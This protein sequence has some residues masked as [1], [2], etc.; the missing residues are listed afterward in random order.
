M[1]YIDKNRA[2]RKISA[3][4][5]KTK[6]KL[7]MNPDSKVDAQD[8]PPESN[9]GSAQ[10]MKRL[11]YNQTKT[12]EIP[13]K[14]A[15]WM[16]L[17]LWLPLFAV[18]QGVGAS[19]WQLLEL[20]ELDQ[21]IANI[22]NMFIPVSNPALL[23]T[24]HANGLGWAHQ[25]D[26]EKLR[27]QYWL[28][29]NSDGLSYVYEY[30]KDDATGRSANQHLLAWGNELLP[31]HILPNLYG[32]LNYSW[33]NNK[34]SEGQFRSGFA[35]R[36]HASASLAFTWDNPYKASPYYR[37]GAA[38]R[39]LAFVP[40]VADHR[41][42]LSADMNYAKDGSDYKFQKPVLGLNTQ[43]LNGVNIGATYNLETETVFANFSLGFGNTELGT[44][45][46]ID[47]KNDND[48]FFIPYIHLPE[49]AFAPFLG[50]TG[51]NWYDM[52]LNQEIVSYRAP[53]YSLGPFKIF[54]K[55]QKS[56]EQV[57]EEIGKA[58]TDP[59]VQ[60][61]MLYNPSFSTSY[62]LMQE[63]IGALQ[64][65]KST[66]KKISVY[67]NNISNGGYVFASAVADKIY[68]NPMGGV[69]LRGISITSPYFRELLDT[70]GIDVLNFRSHKYK[71]AGNM[72]SE[73]EMTAAER[74]VYDSLLQ[75]IYGQMVAMIESGR[76][77]VFKKPVEELIDDGPYFLAVDALNAGLVDELIYEDEVMDR[78]KAEFKIGN[79]K[80]QMEDYRDYAW[81][82]PKENQIAVIYAS[83]SIV[84]GKGTP[85]TKIAHE[86][87]AKMI[88]AARKNKD[89]KGIILRVDSGGG[90]AQASD[91]ILRELELAR[92]ENKKPV[93]VS[94]AG[95]AASGGYYI[96]CK[97]DR[98][99]A[100]PATL[101]GSIGVIGLTF[102]TERLFNKIRVN[103]S[104]VKKGRNADF[105]SLYRS[106]SDEEIRRVEES[107]EA[108]YDDFVNKVDAGRPNLS[109]EQVHEYAQG[110]VWT[111]EQAYA[112][113]LIDDLGG[114]DKALEHM[115]DLT[116]IKGK[117]SLV[118]A[119]ITKDRSVTLGIPLGMGSVSP[120]LELY[121]AATAD[122]QKLYEL[123]R[124]FHNEQVL[125][126]SPLNFADLEF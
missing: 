88:R 96:A 82:K 93:V 99:I 3:L 89:Y 111:G 73:T 48:S 126:L 118:N 95:V 81:S 18:A 119:T 1:F 16:M 123:W 85:G 100:D 46:G 21:P 55:N 66:G 68:L 12:K 114:L 97:A 43:L 120:A 29:L 70:L 13:M 14:H 124:D 113:G 35:Y 76:G 5:M 26:D 45:S 15:L 83:G 47:T 57:I 32:G 50:I 105:G 117:L 6:S 92:T 2:C 30:S 34:F 8:Q 91:I 20:G 24:G 41:L 90:S 17:L 62:A 122:Y 53:K 67:Y 58:K 23:A 74:E 22:D 84:M 106:W 36:P 49:K 39:P 69:D 10:I 11:K 94:M 72:F 115:R 64:E 112:I 42:E 77:S 125:M 78:L 4:I 54:D 31:A 87:T 107:I 121:N 63:L 75:S 61:I 52:K 116:G 79:S 108:I 51:K 38:I 102:N 60:G 25:F 86:T 59:T 109:L 37:F 19:G 7:S 27:N 9:T 103:W 28:F 33:K 44:L 71:N 80:K 56:V 101:T 98:I 110:R 65:F 104:T 40:S